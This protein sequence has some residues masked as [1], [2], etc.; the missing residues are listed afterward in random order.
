MVSNLS[1]FMPIRT[2]VILKRPYQI[3]YKLLCPKWQK[4]ES[5]GAVPNIITWQHI[6][7]RD[8]WFIH[9]SPIIEATGR[10]WSTQTFTPTTYNTLCT[11]ALTHNISL[12]VRT[13][14]ISLSFLPN[15]FSLP[16]PPDILPY[17]PVKLLL[18]LQLRSPPCS[19]PNQGW[20]YC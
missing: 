5:S 4:E 3:I 2:S 6:L 10:R 15:T 14:S 11:H 1:L 9:H 7:A 20:N 19:N 8:Q 18:D 13:Q 12:R 17:L 16:P